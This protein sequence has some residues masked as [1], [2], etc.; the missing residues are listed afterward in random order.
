MITQSGAEGIS[1]KTVR[2]VII[3]EP[4]WNMVRMDQVIGRAVRTYSHE[5]LPESERHVDIEIYTSVF[6][7]AQ[8]RKEFTLKTLDDGLSSDSHILRIAERKDNLTQIFLNYLKVA[9]VDCRTHAHLNKPTKQGLQCYSFPISLQDAEKS[10]ENGAFAYIPDI[11]ADSVSNVKLQRHKKIQG[12]V[13]LYN[14]K[15]YVIINDNRNKLYDYNAYK[16]AGV[17]QFVLSI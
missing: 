15:K 17:L 2:K 10:L 4:F 12:K 8:L 3:M 14:D 9:S 1:L 7:E 5:S 16:E 6:T 11:N 13:V